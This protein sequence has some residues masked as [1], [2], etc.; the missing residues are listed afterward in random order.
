[1]AWALVRLVM[2]QTVSRETLPVAVFFRRRVILM[3][4]RAHGKSR[5]LM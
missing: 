4:W 1:V 3:A 2:A 5:R